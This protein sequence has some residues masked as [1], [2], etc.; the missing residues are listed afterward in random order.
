MPTIPC[1]A[2]I[3]A[4][5]VAPIITEF[6]DTAEIANSTPRAS[7]AAI[8]LELRRLQR[9]YEQVEAPSCVQ[10]A[11][12]NIGGGMNYAVEGFTAFLGEFESAMERYFRVANEYFF[13]VSLVIDP[14]LELDNRMIN[15][16]LVW[17]GGYSNFQTATAFAGLIEE[18]NE[19]A[20]FVETLIAATNSA[21][22]A[23]FAAYDATWTAEAVIP[24]QTAAAYQATVTAMFAPTATLS[25]PVTGTVAS[26]NSVNLRGGP[27]GDYTSI[28][29]VR[30]GTSFTVL[31]VSADGGWYEVQLDDGKTGW[32]SQLLVRIDRSGW[33]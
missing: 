7:L 10:Y 15:P 16:Q 12:R 11:A 27:G 6:F 9:G 17:G 2:S 3:W 30:P 26:M 25:F 20:Y 29:T 33:G 19:G 32:I 31:G 18:G 13:A 8:L 23:T 22:D 1:D 14:T 24:L 28:G 4:A 5:A 21:W